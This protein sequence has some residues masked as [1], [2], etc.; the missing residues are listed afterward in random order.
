MVSGTVRLK[1][2]LRDQVTGAGMLTVLV[3]VGDQVGGRV[4]VRVLVGERKSDRVAVEVTVPL[5]LVVGVRDAVHDQE[6]VPGGDADWVEVAL[7]DGRRDREAL[8]ESV[9]SA[10][11]VGV[12]VGEAGRVLDGVEVRVGVGPVGEPVVRLPVGLLEGG[13]GGKVG[14]LVALRVCACVA[15]RV[16]VVAVGVEDPLERVCGSVHVGVTVA[17]PSAVGVCVAEHVTELRVVVRVTV[18]RLAEADGWR[19]QLDVGL[20]LSTLDA[21]WDLVGVAVYAGE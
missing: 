3:G 10:E 9:G 4:P 18:R 8:P 19:L 11:L 15:V 2:G 20:K 5:T 16:R 17:V 13:L 14:V 1:L 12:R 21:V 7:T 6:R